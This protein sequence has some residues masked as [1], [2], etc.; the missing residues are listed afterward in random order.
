MPLRL[1]LGLLKGIV[2][3]GLVGYA[4]AAAGLAAPS[5]W[6]AYPIAAAVGMAIATIA[7]KP[8]W[9]K[10]ARIE[11]GMKAAAAAV[12]APG[13][14]WLART[15]LTVGLPFE[16]S[17]LPG[18]SAGAVTLGTFSI[19]SLALVAAVLGGFFEADNQPAPPDEKQG[20]GGPKKRID[21]ASPPTAAVD[22]LED[23]VEEPARRRA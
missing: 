5:A 11:V 10:D 15:F 16:P 22:E 18:V 23:D 17:L 20:G 14:M 12:V 1:V 13:L 7:G 21:A 3:G 8:I 19:T 6:L 2:L 4:L 9:A